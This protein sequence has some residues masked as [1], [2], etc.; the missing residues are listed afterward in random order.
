[1]LIR[2]IRNIAVFTG[3]LGILQIL[4]TVPAGYFGYAAVL[5][6]LLGCAAAII[7]F[8]LMG[9]IL[10]KC[11]SAERGAAGLMGFGYIGRLAIIAAAVVWAMKVSYLNYVCVI[12]PLIFPQIAIFIL[13]AVRNKERKSDDERT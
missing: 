9:I 7:N 6:A 5:G 12:I 4:I 11:V 3:V 10:E 1:M 13:N 8:A 2:E